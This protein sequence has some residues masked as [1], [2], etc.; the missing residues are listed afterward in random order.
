[1]VFVAMYLSEYDQRAYDS[2]ARYRSFN[3]AKNKQ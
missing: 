1:M 2:M 3:D